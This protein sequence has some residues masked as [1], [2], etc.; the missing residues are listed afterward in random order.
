MAEVKKR[1][2]PVGIQS[3]RKIRQEG[4]LYVDKTDL[5][6]DLVNKCKVIGLSIELDDLGKGLLDWEEVV[7]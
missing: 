1:R 4:F 6:W 3:F 5:V 2:L 7:E